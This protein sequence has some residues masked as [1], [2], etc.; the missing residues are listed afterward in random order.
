M[1]DINFE[2]SLKQ[3]E[4]VRHG[5]ILFLYR[6]SILCHDHTMKTLNILTTSS[7]IESE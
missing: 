5:N 4:T 6:L 3:E 7:D 1:K 2:I